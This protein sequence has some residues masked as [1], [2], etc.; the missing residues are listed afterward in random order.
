[1][2]IKKHLIVV[3]IANN[4]DFFE[5]SFPEIIGIENS[6]ILVVDDGSLDGSDELINEIEG[7][8]CI[9]HEQPL[10][11]GANII[12]GCEYG[13][14]MG[15]DTLL[16]IDPRNKNPKTDI[17]QMIAEMN[18][19]YDY[20]SCSRIL[21]N[22]DAALIKPAYIEMMEVL[23]AAVQE[24]LN[25]D[26]TDPL[27]GIFAVKTETFNKMELTDYTHA[28]LLQILVQAASLGITSTEIPASS[29]ESFGMEFDEYDDPV[30]DFLAAFETEKYLYLR[31]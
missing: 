17:E 10:G 20:V 6:D 5:S 23:S 11:F 12:T 8:V 13:R 22:L 7:I 30:G 4:R 18:Y 31:D 29:G 14:D 16:Y 28:V 9:R 27:S 3:P 15:Y 21:E 25:I 19:G 26:I 2:T 1:M 24:A